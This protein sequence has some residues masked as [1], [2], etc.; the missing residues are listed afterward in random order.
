[1]TLIVGNDHILYV[2][3]N[4][5]SGLYKI[6]VSQKTVFKSLLSAASIFTFLDQHAFYMSGG[7][8]IFVCFIFAADIT[9]LVCIYCMCPN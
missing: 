8:T 6:Q 5:V 9:L 2:H 7:I 3:I 1:M 4:I